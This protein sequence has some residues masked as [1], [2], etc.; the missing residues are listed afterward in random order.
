[1]TEIAL[2]MLQ[3]T[4]DD[5]F[6]DLGCGDGR[7]VA[8]A[9]R[10]GVRRG[11]GIELDAELAGSARRRVLAALA[12]GDDARR[13]TVLVGDLCSPDLAT[14]DGLSDVTAAFLFLSPR[15]AELLSSR[16]RRF[17]SQTL[18]VCSCDF[19]LDQQRWT[20]TQSR[21]VMDLELHAYTS[22]VS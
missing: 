6:V 1:V 7:V 5:V 22:R 17:G 9:L 4:P 20:L 15:G 19:R 21:R 11:I 18:R 12:P 16:A 14:E 3:L 8:A 2:D 13:G 10:R